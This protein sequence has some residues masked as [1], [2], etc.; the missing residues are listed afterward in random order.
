MNGIRVLVDGNQVFRFPTNARVE[1][2]TNI[3]PDP[4]I[5]GRIIKLTNNG[6]VTLCEL[7]VYVRVK[8]YP[9]KTKKL[10]ILQAA[11]QAVTALNVKKRVVPDVKRVIPSPG[12]ARADLAG[13]HHHNVKVRKTENT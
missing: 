6:Y 9:Q 11:S 8:D 2:T 10:N 1:T 5:S 13:R 12:T 3:T 4:P 7:E